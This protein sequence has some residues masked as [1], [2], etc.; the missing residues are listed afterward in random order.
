MAHVARLIGRSKAPGAEPSWER[1]VTATWV[2]SHLKLMTWCQ[3]KNFQYWRVKAMDQDRALNRPSA[4]T[5]SSCC[6]NIRWK[7]YPQFP[8]MPYQ[9]KFLFLFLFTFLANQLR[10]KLN[11]RT[12]TALQ[13]SGISCRHFPRGT[14]S[15][16]DYSVPFTD[17]VSLL[18]SSTTSPSITEH[19]K[20]TVILVNLPN[21]QQ[22]WICIECVSRFD[23]KG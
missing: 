10:G 14:A 15:R 7:W 21:A 5:R 2:S 22:K 19:T 6:N 8:T 16:Q 4:I 20:Y 13:R 23:F 1:Q 11:Q 3:K 17:Y 12:S 18:N 9:M